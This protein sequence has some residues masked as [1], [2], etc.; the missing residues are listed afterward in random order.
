MRQYWR[1]V[2]CKYNGVWMKRKKTLES[3]AMDHSNKMCYP[4][5][6]D[7]SSSKQQQYSNTLQSSSSKQQQKYMGSIYQYMLVRRAAAYSR[8]IIYQ[9][10]VLCCAT[11]HGVYVKKR[12]ATTVITIHSRAAA[13]A[14]AALLC[15]WY[16]RKT[17]FSIAQTTPQSSSSI[18]FHWNKQKREISQKDRHRHPRFRP[19]MKTSK[20]HQPTC[21][22]PKVLTWQFFRLT[23]IY[24]YY[25]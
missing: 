1:G 17:D 21:S 2:H 19:R 14:A 3:D 6:D 13:A 20:G 10:K 12:E 8:I 4:A 16:A 18:F 15:T 11:A 9:V 23:C 25:E 24:T 22:R 7:N 5:H